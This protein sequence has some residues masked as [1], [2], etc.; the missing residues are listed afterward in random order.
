MQ[1]K[2]ADCDFS[3]VHDLL[4]DEGIEFEVVY[5]TLNNSQPAVDPF[6]VAEML[7]GLKQESTMGRIQTVNHVNVHDNTITD[8]SKQREY[9]ESRA[10]N[11]FYTK[12]D[13]IPK[14][15]NLT[16]DD[17]PKD[18][19]EMIERIKEGKYALLPKRDPNSRRYE[20]EYNDWGDYVGLSRRIKWKDPTKVADQEGADKAQDALR[21]D[22]TK[23]KDII[24]V[25]DAEAGLAAVQEFESKTYH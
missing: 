6:P 3:D 17:P 25:K 15:F 22:F 18:T 24:M 9:L 20:D 16:D 14:L 13:E 11:I 1:I 12:A 8:I 19:E 2:F 4:N 7:Q 10:R 5:N 23:V 21:V